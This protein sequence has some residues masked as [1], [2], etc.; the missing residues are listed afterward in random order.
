M[1]FTD[2]KAEPAVIVSTITAALVALS[3]VV[4]AFGANLTDTQQNAMI[5]AV[6]PL[7]AVIFVLGPIIRQLVYAPNTTQAIANNAAATGN[8]TIPAPPATDVVDTK[9]ADAAPVINP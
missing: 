7:V 8:P 6:A 5:G 3:G 9:P 1:R 2:I 4:V